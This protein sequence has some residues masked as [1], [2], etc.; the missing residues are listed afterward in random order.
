MDFASAEKPNDLQH[1]ISEF[2]LTEY[3]TIFKIQAKV[4]PSELCR[5]GSVC[6]MTLTI[7]KVHENSFADLMYEVLADQNMWAVVGRTAGMFLI[8]FF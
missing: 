4:E 1:F 8:Q 5:V 7:T 2:D 3:L 6:H